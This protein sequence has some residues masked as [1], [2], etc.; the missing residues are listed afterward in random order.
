MV[1]ASFFIPL[2]FLGF[3]T[4]AGG[5]KGTIFDQNGQPLPFAT[6][7]VKEVESG[8]TSNSDGIYQ[9]QLKPGAYTIT[10]QYIGYEAL[11]KQITVG[12]DFITVDITLKEQ[13]MVLSDVQIYA[14]KE[15]PAYTI[16]RKAIA[17]AK[18]H[19]QQIDRY[20]A[21]VYIKGTGRLKD[22]PFFLR[23]TLEKEGVTS[24]RVFISESVSEVEYIRPNTYKEKVISVYTTG[25][26]NDNASPNG[27]VYGSFYEP[28]LAKSI[29]PLSPKAFSYYRFEYDGT[30]R[31]EGYE[32]SKIK[33]IPRSRGDNVF[34]GVIN[35][36]EDYW[37][38]YS[39]DLTT[40]KLGIRFD[41]R[42]IYKPVEDKAWLP[43]THEFDVSGTVL[44]FEFEG[45]YLATVSDYDIELNPDLDVELEVIDEKVEKELAKEITQSVK[46]DKN[47]ETL[48][49]LTSGEEV[50]RKQLS[51]LIRA[52]EKAEKEEL[53]EPEVV[54]NRSFKVDSLAYKRDSAYWAQIRPVPLSNLEEKGY[55]ITDSLAQVEKKEAEGDTLNVKKDRSDFQFYHILTGGR[56]KVGKRGHFEIDV[57]V[58][59]YN[60]VEGYNIDYSLSYDRNFDNENKSWI[61]FRPT[62]RYAFAREKLSGFMNVQYGF[63]K[64]GRRHDLR[65]RAGRYI[66]QFNT[67][68]PIHPTINSLMSLMLEQNYM[69]IYEKDFAQ[70]S[71]SKKISDRVNLQVDFLGEDRTELFNNT[72]YRFWDVEGDNFTD[73]QPNNFVV[74]S[75]SF[76]DHRAVIA[77][78]GMSYR[79][80]LK[81]RI[82]NDKKYPITENTPLFNFYYKKGISGFAG[83]DVD[84]DLL[85][86]GLTY[87]FKIGVR[88]LVDLKMIAG[89]FLN[90]DQLYFMDFK[91]FLGNQTPLI[92]TDPV[93]TFRLLDYYE[94]STPDEYFT[95]NLQY[96]FRKFLVTRIPIA[97]LTGVREG[98]F[99]NYLTTSNLKPYTE[100][101]YGI[102]YIFR[103]LRLEAVANFYEGQY[104]DWG[105]RLGLATNFE[106]IF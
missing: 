84:Y 29:S 99:V 63:G 104:Q 101:G 85:E 74:P 6:V 9:I 26:S 69:K 41:I 3:S 81:Y 44:G 51:K 61:K 103:I 96:Q 56:Y 59:Q 12:S 86:L 76:P 79:P 66:S 60:T 97:R 35:I 17:K 72:T 19:I 95:A 38:I 83:S 48:E 43:V 10:Y 40:Y 64:V 73:N 8:T 25:E 53:D 88:G 106:D 54:V 49:Q 102:N 78:V 98:F 67:E 32:V 91:H 77:K 22:A 15:D 14:G 28:E 70:I 75:T 93:G 7:Y 58:G 21:R 34:E 46:K 55:S 71:Y 94:F 36:V 20:T 87:D 4:F 33:V 42:Q 90:N 82:Y 65:L 62:F 52:Y 16:M 37:S 18:F 105:I 68:D 50:T 57:P 80:W 1:R 92:T 39:L 24:D 31:E 45:E 47:K 89:K 100:V 13:V 30:F 23:K 11:T 2:L 27:Y 5:I